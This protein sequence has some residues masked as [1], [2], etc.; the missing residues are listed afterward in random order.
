[1]GDRYERRAM[2][3]QVEMLLRRP[4]IGHNGGPP[5]DMSGEAWLWRRVIAKAW[6]PPRPEV[7]LRRLARAEALG[8]TYREF[9]A[10]ILDT[11]VHLSTAVMPLGLAAR[12]KRMGGER[13]IAEARP[14]M[15]QR[16]ARFGGRLFL[17]ADPL[18]HGA[19]DE[20]VRDEMRLAL[21]RALDGKIEAIGITEPSAASRHDPRAEAVRA[22]LRRH[23]APKQEAFF[24]G[25]GFA[26]VA[27][28][29]AAAL[30]LFKWAH[31]WFSEVA[32]G[33]ST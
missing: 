14:E 4:G 22:M 3:P 11:G 32:S 24:V 2:V 5:F 29:E 17:L 7:A 20:G 9:T 16:I 27:L 25:T 21:N 6:T 10:V 30:P 26:D 28:A 31:E 18:L 15:A 13:A 19:L 12:V 23:G 1:M 33:A 8:V